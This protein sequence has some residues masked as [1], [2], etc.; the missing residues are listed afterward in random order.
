VFLLFHCG[1]PAAWPSASPSG[2]FTSRTVFL[3]PVPNPIRVSPPGTDSTAIIRTPPPSSG[4]RH[5]CRSCP[6][7]LP[8]SSPDRP[9]RDSPQR[10]ARIRSR[11]ALSRRVARGTAALRI[12][13][14]LLVAILFTAGTFLV[15]CTNSPSPWRALWHPALAFFLLCLANLVAI[16][17][18]ESCEIRGTRS[19]GRLSAWLA[20]S[21]PIWR[22]VLVFSCLAACFRPSAHSA[23]YFA[24]A[25]SLIA[26]LCLY[27][28][29]R[30]LPLELRRTVVGAVRLSP[31]YFYDERR[32][33]RARLSLA[34]ICR[35]QTLARTLAG[36]FAISDRWF[37]SAPTSTDAIRAFS[38][39]GSTIN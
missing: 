1:P 31:W 17:R 5:D 3:T 11:H 4:D 2:Q 35:L 27:G 6:Q 18:W 37:C 8:P 15:A 13:K 28:L 29:G 9:Q 14:E 36:S 30:R 12:P 33:D 32:S 26:T 24:I 19:P 23:W 25:L 21:Y 38:L 34:R 20:R 22:S 10:T 39:T 7:S 16:D